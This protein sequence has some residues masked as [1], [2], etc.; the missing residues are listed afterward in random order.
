MAVDSKGLREPYAGRVQGH[1]IELRDDARRVEIS[2]GGVMVASTDRAVVLQE[3]GLPPR[4]YVP[5]EDVRTDLLDPTDKA[6]ACPF[7]GAASY[8]SVEI[9]D[10]RHENVVWSYEDPI[11]GMERIAGRFAFFDEIVDVV[12]DGEAQARPQTQWTPGVVP[13][14]HP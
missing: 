12:I 2:V 4:Y 1:S 8:W 13:A 11:E 5:R 3:T 14:E 7:K 9:G 6:T 10:R